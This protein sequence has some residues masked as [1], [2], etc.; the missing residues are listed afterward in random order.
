MKP[1]IKMVRFG[2]MI[3]WMCQGHPNFTGYGLTPAEAYE[4]WIDDL[5]PF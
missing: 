2:N 4:C 1:R 3:W 5:I